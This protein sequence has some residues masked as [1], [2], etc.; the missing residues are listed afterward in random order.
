MTLEVAPLHGP[1]ECLLPAMS[2]MGRLARRQKYPVTRVGRV[3]V[4]VVTSTNAQPTRLPYSTMP[5]SGEVLI[6]YDILT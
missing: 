3:T 6:D 2:L 5:S 4:R 1:Q